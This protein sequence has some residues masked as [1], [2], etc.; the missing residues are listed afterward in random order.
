MK[1][2]NKGEK[3]RK[4]ISVATLYAVLIQQI[5]PYGYAASNSDYRTSNSFTNSSVSVESPGSIDVKSSPEMEELFEA[6]PGLEQQVKVMMTTAN[7]GGQAESSG[8]SLGST[9]GMVDKFTGDFSY[10]IPLMDVEGYPITIAYNSNISMN[11]DASWVGLGWDLNVGSV[12]RE[13]RGIPDEFNG[14]QKI[15]RTF[16]Q[17]DGYTDSHKAGPFV[18]AGINLPIPGT[19][20]LAIVPSIQLTLLKGKYYSS[21]VGNGR[22]FDFNVGGSL[23]LTNDRETW[24]VGPTFGIGYSKDSKNGIGTSS[25]FGIS[26]AY[27]DKEGG[28]QGGLSV[29]F[30]RSYNSRIGI[31]S[32]SLNAGFT[33]G[34]G[35]IVEQSN[36]KN[37]Y[38]SNGSSSIGAGTAITYGTGTMVPGIPMSTNSSGNQSNTQGSIS[39]GIGPLLQVGVGSMSQ[40]ALIYNESILN[41]NEQIEQ[42]AIGYFH[43]GKRAQYATNNVLQPLMDFNRSQGFEYSEN[44]EYL[45]FSAQTY[46]VF[47]VNSAGISGTYR[48]RRTDFGTYHDAYNYSP[49]DIQ[50]ASISAGLLVAPI[51]ETSF[52]GSY[53]L[54]AGVQD[55]GPLNNTSTKL[56]FVGQVKSDK[57]DNTVYFKSI[58]E[59]TPEDLDALNSMG[60]ER[61]A[62]FEM[63]KTNDEIYLTGA[64]SWKTLNGGVGASAINTAT[65]NAQL[66]ERVQ[67]SQF[68]PMLP[69]DF[70]ETN[71]E[72]FY[73]YDENDFGYGTNSTEILRTDQQRE[74][75]HLSGVVSVTASG[76]KYV[77]GIPAYNLNESTVAFAATGLTVDAN[78][79][80][81]GGYTSADNSTSNTRGR[82][83]YYDKTTV[84]AYAHSFLLTQM[85]S[86]NYIDLT[87][88]GPSVDDVGSY[89]KF[90]YSQAYGNETDSIYKWRFPAAGG[91]SG[92]E[93][94]FNKGTLGSELDDKANYSYGEK[95]IWYVHTVESKNF[96]AEF[97]VEDRLDAYGVI[98]EN[99]VLDNNTPLKALTKIVLY[100]R[101]ERVD[102]GYNLPI[103]IIEFEYDYSL[104]KNSPNNK[105]TYSP[106]IDYGKSGK[107]TL[108]TIRV[109]SGESHESALATYEFTY[110]DF[111]PDFNYASVD[112]WGNYKWNDANKPNDIFPY[113]KQ[114]LDSANLN[115]QAWKLTSIKT[116]IGGQMDV[117]YEADRFGY[118][119][120]KEA[121]RHFE[122][123]GMTNLIDFM[124]ILED[125][126][127]DGSQNTGFAYNKYFSKP[128]LQSAG[129]S[130]FESVFNNNKADLKYEKQFGLMERERV[131]NN[132][133]IFKLEQEYDDTLTWD[134]A[135][136]QVKDE[137]FGDLVNATGDD[138]RLYLKTLSEIDQDGLVEDYVPFFA[139][140]SQDY[141]GQERVFSGSPTTFLDQF[142][143]MGVM[144]NYG[145]NNYKYGYVVLEPG[146]VAKHSRKELG[147]YDPDD[148]FAK[149][150]LQKAVIE[151]AR[152]HLP[153]IIYGACDGCND[154]M[155]LV[156]DK[157]MTGKKDA[158][159]VMMEL[160]FAENMISGLSTVRLYEPD[161][162]KFGGNA[163]VS[164]ITYSDNWDAI[165]GEYASTYSWNYDYSSSIEESGVAAHE[166]GAMLDENP[167]YKWLSYENIVEKFPNESK[168]TPTPIAN[169]LYP[170]SQV[171]YERVQVRFNN[172][173]DKGYSESQFHTAKTHPVIWDETDINTD[174][175]IEKKNFLIGMSINLYGLSQGYTLITN[176][177]HGRPFSHSVYDQF[178]DV[179]T[180]ANLQSK[181]VYDYFDSDEQVKMI[182]RD[183]NITEETIAMEYDMHSD[184][185][186]V[187][188]RS[189]SAMAGLTLKLKWPG[190]VPIPLVLP[191]VSVGSRAQGFYSNVFVK[192]INKSAVV[193]NVQ[194]DYLGSVNNASN[195]AYDYETGNVLISSLQDEYN[196]SLYSISYPAHWYYDQF[197]SRTEV[198][199]LVVSGSVTGQSLTTNAQL[200]EQFVA[201]DYLL[202]TNGGA[203]VEAW[204]LSISGTTATL[205]EESGAI[206]DDITGNV[207]VT[208]VNSGRENRLMESMQSIVTKKRPDLSVG[209]F[210]FPMDEI[211][212][213]SAITYR[214]RNNLKCR[215][216]SDGLQPLEAFIGQITNPY[217]IGAKGYLVPD[218]SFSWQS[219][220]INATHDHGTRFDGTYDNLV[221]FYQISSNEW[222]RINETNH[223]ENI[224]ADDYQKWRKLGETTLFDQ[225]GKALE[226]KDQIDIQSAVLYGYNH[227]LEIVPVAQAVNAKKQQ[228]A[229]DGFEDYDYYEG[230]NLYLESTH[231]NFADAI[232][233]GI[234]LTTSH[235]HSGLSSLQVDVN[236]TAQITKDVGKDWLNPTDG[237][238]STNFTADSCLCIPSFAPTPGKYII[239]AWVK[240]GASNPTAINYT[241]ALV[242]V[243]VGGGMATSYSFPP[244]GP[245]LDGWQRVEGTFIIPSGGS[246]IIVEL[247]NISSSL[248][249]YFDDVRI[250]PYL[251]GMTTTVYDPKTLLPLATHDGYNFTT[252]YNYD[253]NLNQVRVRVETIDGIKT[254]SETEFGGQKSFE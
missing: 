189:E 198:E 12:S 181:T 217:L 97:Y 246:T 192:H 25:Q 150:P 93:A 81:V 106:N 49:T 158:N 250:H 157:E 65:L 201:G 177:F 196:D 229:Y 120:D 28:V 50:S 86:S 142:E 58:G 203:P 40:D 54:N 127:Y 146:Q 131:P 160:E 16:N 111:N 125:D 219:P 138:R 39:T 110:D 212:S 134:E 140:I 23:S 88:D 21:Q 235:R 139:T 218:G 209:A 236:R 123:H 174:Q 100:N 89:Y 27:G 241:D 15:V 109:R 24:N 245:I 46:D 251:A 85:L 214:D 188:D 26:G 66:N 239:G 38:I 19:S 20:N 249:V 186:F 213:S 78:T 180:P 13:M 2:F 216:G 137:Y 129:G 73:T 101:S 206:F 191:T 77:Y 72:S 224:P 75:N 84:P 51:P 136:Q 43:N 119:Q 126:S 17:I 113:V 171:G 234:A 248:E 69:A 122:I 204:I 41:L 92:N 167:L 30:G 79:G 3:F 62:Y 155:L 8:F 74:D 172:G 67:A 176:D 1:L 230:T 156:V 48:G 165:S 193:R 152:G 64:L 76:S 68:L 45:D 47:R 115:V 7:G 80:I 221:P 233:S 254:I 205:I 10:S 124:N 178:G 237:M 132:V 161:N 98:D 228:I 4:V 82:S 130:F 31:S 121:M 128:D 96:I 104:C 168:F 94:F 210:D 71:S 240:V 163:R 197:R 63:A 37:K 194:T 102:G 32:K 9:D 83:H 151:Y 185:H 118:V 103:Q 90:N 55:S 29:S 141:L 44:M 53:G 99:G 56:A 145:S 215:I 244:S 147:E 108:K 154:A 42:P 22:T 52:G 166:S 91:T 231:F 225:Y 11:S 6:N 179:N 190:P 143:A 173:Y 35:E 36:G 162:I 59:S 116:P 183:G 107:L 199:G 105:Y 61:A 242:N 112:G 232:Q 135:A 187:R 182:D 33:M 95:E 133:I 169:L 207:T 202:I 195:L 170:N 208:L 159:K 87:N 253:E 200:S 247:E 117:E 184:A 223:P 220:R 149:H 175:R 5:I 34:Y 70:D 60:G 238:S 226:S 144:P 252:F 114:D 222:Y 18:T 153:D 211:I 57:F 243:S 227:E 148:R 164:Q 14:E